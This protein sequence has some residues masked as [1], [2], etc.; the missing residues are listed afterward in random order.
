MQCSDNLLALLNDSLDLSKIEAEHL[1]LEELDFDLQAT[2]NI[3]T[4]PLVPLARD[5]GVELVIETSPALPAIL[6]GDPVRLR[7]IITNLVGNAIKFTEQGE[8]RI[9][10][11]H[12]AEDA[13][14][15]T[16]RFEI[17]DTGAGIPAEHLAAIFR[18]FVQAKTSTSRKYGGTGLGLSIS[19]KL[20]ELFHGTIG[21]ESTEGAGSTFW[22]TAVF[23]KA[24]ALSDPTAAGVTPV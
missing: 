8:I 1:Q 20:V 15:T 6:C 10:T 19:K 5:K 2:L 23:R 3:A 16:L 7:Q 24:G 12:A 18:P 13:T 14:T 17:L 22:F 4:L 11:M 21:A 9:R